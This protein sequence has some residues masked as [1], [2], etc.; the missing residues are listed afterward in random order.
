VN[1]PSP[2]LGGGTVHN[3]SSVRK[4]VRTHYHGLAALPVDLALLD[5]FVL[6]VV[7]QALRQQR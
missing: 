3:L 4:P 1:K 5:M 2:S 6:E 7:Q